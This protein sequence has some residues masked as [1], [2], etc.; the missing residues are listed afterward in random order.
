MK[1]LIIV[2]T[3]V[4]L[5]GC[6]PEHTSDQKEDTSVWSNTHSTGTVLIWGALTAVAAYF[7]L[8]KPYQTL[9]PLEESHNENSIKHPHL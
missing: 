5:L 3:A 7:L 2:L 8:V 6:T 4:A 1:N 9:P